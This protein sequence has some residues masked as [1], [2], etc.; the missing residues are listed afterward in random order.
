MKILP[1]L[2]L[3][4][5][6]AQA[7]EPPV[8]TE[9]PS[10]EQPRSG[11]AQL[12]LTGQQGQTLVLRLSDEQ[13]APRIVIFDRTYWCSDDHRLIIGI[14]FEQ[15]PGDYDIVSN[16]Y[17]SRVKLGTLRVLETA[18][19]QSKPRGWYRPAAGITKRRQQE[20][21]DI[22][23]ALARG[24]TK[25]PDFP[26]LKFAQPPLETI[27]VSGDPFGLFRRAKKRVGRRKV[28]IVATDHHRGTDLSTDGKVGM[29]V[30]SMADGVVVLAGRFTREGNMVIIYHG[31]GVYSL[32]MHLSRFKVRMDKPV[33]AGDIVALSGN[34]GHSTGPHLHYSVYVN[35]AV[36][37]SI[38][39][40]QAINADD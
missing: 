24:E 31:A 21:N 39:F 33:N 20:R 36:V 9:I 16:Q 6:P 4:A 18:F 34:T 35:G 29:P 23:Y 1:F 32:S 22:S 11:E 37:D 5:M 3:L 25:Y 12:A 30:Q 38:G 15:S 19:E 28:E 8:L 40:I 10:Q 17:D 2:F 27:A 14:D 13:C 26:A 7:Q